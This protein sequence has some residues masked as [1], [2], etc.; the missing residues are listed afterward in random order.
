MV[1]NYLKITLR[2]L[3]KHRVYTAINILGLSI[4]FICCLFIAIYVDDELK[5]DQFHSRSDDIYRVTRE[6]FSQDG[7]TSL[8]LSQIAPPFAVYF[9]EDFPEMEKVC[10]IAFYGGTVEYEGKIFDEENFGFAD[11]E[12]FDIFSFN[13][14]AGDPKTALTEPGTIVITEE[15]SNRYFGTPDG[16]NKVIRFSDMVNFKVTGIIEEIPETSHFELELIANF[17]AVEEY[18]GGR[19]RMMKAWGSN[20]YSTYF[21]LKEG[22]SIQSIDSRFPDFLTKHVAEDANEWNA[23]HIQKMTDIHLKSN[24]DNEQG[25]NSDITYVYIFISIGLLILFIACINYM[26]LAT[27]RS[28]NRAKEVGMRKVLGAGKQNLIYQFLTESIVLVIIA[29][30]ISLVIVSATLPYFREFTDRQLLLDGNQLM[31][32]LGMITVIGI[33]IGVLAGSY[34][35]FFLSSFSPLKV[36]KGKLASG[37]KSSS[38]RKVLVVVQFSISVVLIASTVIVFDQINYMSNKDLGYQTEQMLT[39]RLSDTIKEKYELFKNVLLEHPSIVSI[40][41]SR[42]IPSGQLLDSSGAQAE[43]DGEMQ[44]PEVVIK[45]LDA[46]YDFLDTYE[47]EMAAGRW[48]S[49][50]YGSDD[51]A[52]F[53]LNEEAVRI[54]GWETNDEAIG[55]SFTYGGREGRVVGI[56]KNIHFESLRSEINPL[57]M[58]IPSTSNKRYMSIRVKP[59]ELPE[60]LKYIEGKWTEFSPKF[61]IEYRFLDD[62]FETLYQSETQ[63]SKLF[64][65]FSFLAIFLA[66]LGLLGLASFTVAQRTKEISIRKVLGASLQAILLVLSKEFLVLVIASVI[67]GAPITWLFMSD[68]LDGYAYRIDLTILPFVIAGLISLIIAISTIGSQTIKAATS[69]PVKGLRDE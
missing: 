49:K 21:L 27:A 58:F 19:E 56:S 1:K 45:R 30:I 17:M 10:R 11:P 67:V 66:C 29:I 37:A 64:T 60:T 3:K 52:A 36:L 12:I 23:L 4:G 69:N 44:A 24:L 13:F 8:H 33:M 47:M 46:G 18:Y 68:W 28:A 42:R 34:P 6:F 25:M 9:K 20:N 16:M 57:V 41:S 59:N 63:R 61:P 22:E 40:G 15:I 55:K 38:L 35:A 62:R 32:W 53:V 14:T 2:S 39:I 7:T 65:G 26:N 54:V 31:I 48:F 43:I 5:Y 51:T 50:S